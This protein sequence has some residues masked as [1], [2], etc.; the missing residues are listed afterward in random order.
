M[1]QRSLSNGSKKLAHSVRRLEGTVKEC[2]GSQ[3]PERRVVP[4]NKQ[5]KNRANVTKEN[6][7]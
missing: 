7:V 4:G 1:W 3:G 5:K 2:T 6:V